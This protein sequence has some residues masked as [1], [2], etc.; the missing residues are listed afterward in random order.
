MTIIPLLLSALLLPP[1]GHLV[2]DRAGVLNPA[3][4]ARLDTN[5]RDYEKA[6]SNEVAVLILPSLE[7]S[8]VEEVATS[9]FH[10][11]G[12]G[13]KGKDNGV[14][15]LIAVKER[16]IRIEVGYGLEGALPDARSGDIIRG[17]I[18]PRLKEGKWDQG[19]G[20]GLVAITSALAR[21][22]STPPTPPS[23][24]SSRSPWWLLAFII[25]LG[26]IGVAG[27]ML[28]LQ[29][30]E[31]ARKEEERRRKAKEKVWA[32]PQP[33]YYPPARPPVPLVAS[34]KSMTSP[35]R[36]RSANVAPVS[37]YIPVETYIAPASY[38]PPSSSSSFSSSSSDFSSSSSD[39]SFGGGDSGGG[40][41]SGDF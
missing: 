22:A 36:S 31:E 7:G 10:S 12:I 34:R 23:P 40:G 27:Y 33:H 21:P 24:P 28:Y 11:W 2:T 30:E 16:K 13:K 14:L 9:I 15:L 35:T 3:N 19:V 17:I 5:M 29:S 37:I 38:D 4:V 8:S 20:D 18:A 32:T 6:T 39:F 41:A 26:L 1:S 25:P